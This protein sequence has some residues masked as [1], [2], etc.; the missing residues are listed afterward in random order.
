MKERTEFTFFA[1]R[2]CEEIFDKVNQNFLW[3]ACKSKGTPTHFI[4]DPDILR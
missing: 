2:D 4:L 1:L 3:V